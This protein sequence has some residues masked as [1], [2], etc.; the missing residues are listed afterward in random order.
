MKTYDFKCGRCGKEFP[1][2]RVSEPVDKDPV[3]ITGTVTDEGDITYKVIMGFVGKRL[4]F[5]D[6]TWFEREHIVEEAIKPLRQEIIRLR[7][8]LLEKIENG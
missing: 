3:K 1:E 6:L 5:K 4:N 8:M 7:R 2:V